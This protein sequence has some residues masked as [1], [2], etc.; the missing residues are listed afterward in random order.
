MRIYMK[1][2]QYNGFVLP[3][4]PPLP[5]PSNT[6]GDEAAEKSLGDDRETTAMNDSQW[7]ITQQ[8]K[9]LDCALCVMVAYSLHCVFL[10]APYTSLFLSSLLLSSLLV[11]SFSWHVT[12]R[13]YIIDSILRKGGFPSWGGEPSSPFMYRPECGCGLTWVSRPWKTVGMFVS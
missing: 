13:H 7:I 4:P 5:L 3:P 1:T 12:F 8:P 2:V 6:Q 10:C 9:N 11:H